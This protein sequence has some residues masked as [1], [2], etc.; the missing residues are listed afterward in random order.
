MGKEAF[1]QQQQISMQAEVPQEWH[2]GLFS[3]FDDIGICL[4]G[5]LCPFCLIGDNGSKLG[6]S[7]C[8]DCCLSFL[9][10]EILS[11]DCFGPTSEQHYDIRR[12]A[13]LKEGVYN[14]CLAWWCCF[15]CAACQHANEIK[16]RSSQGVNMIG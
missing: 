6:R 9:C 2:F 15:T 3:C 12:R 14:G 7:C 4:Y 8:S 13:N 16:Y 5:C 1:Q 10:V 11:G